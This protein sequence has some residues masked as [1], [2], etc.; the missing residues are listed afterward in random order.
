MGAIQDTYLR[1]EAAGDQYVG[2]VVAGLPICSW[3][4]A[5]LPP[6]IVDCD[7]KKVEEIVDCCFPS[8]PDGLKY[9]ARFL[10]ASLLYH[11]DEI[12][13]YIPSTHPLLLASFLTSSEIQEIILKI[14]INYAWDE[15]VEVEVYKNQDGIQQV[16]EASGELSGSTGNESSDTVSLGSEK[17]MPRRTQRIRKATG[18]PAHVMLMADM[19]RVI[20]SQ[21]SVIAQVACIIKK[22]F[23][24]REVGHATFQ[25]QHQV[26]K[27]LS[28]FESRVVTKLDSLKQKSS[29]STD[30]CSPN[31]LSATIEGGRWYHW[32]GHYRKVPSDWNFPN[33]MT[34]RT[35]IHRYY[36]PDLMND[37]C[38]LKYLTGTDVIKCKNGRRNI[39]SLHMLMK[40]MADEAKN[41]SIPTL[42]R[43]PTED[44]INK[45]YR[46]VSGFVLS[47]SNNPRSESFTWQTHA[48]YG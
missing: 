4:F 13:K 30:E 2:R 47:L 14:Q 42:P 22:E 43:K 7:V 35:A 27:M 8:L 12:F 33:K 48:T 24:Q 32:E 21:Q 45:Y 1:Y 3:K 36:L 9:S 38:P 20:R 41:K 11:L 5:V 40:F 17:T 31:G 44:D 29:S 28:S 10:S 34:L 19:Q 23:D 16:E 15:D 6:Q 46:M 39:S 26:E 18:I 25:V 37:I